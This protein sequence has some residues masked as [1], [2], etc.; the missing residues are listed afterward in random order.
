MIKIYLALIR[1]Y[2]TL[3]NACYIPIKFTDEKIQQTPDFISYT[4]VI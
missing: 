2:F 3:K 1:T 4:P